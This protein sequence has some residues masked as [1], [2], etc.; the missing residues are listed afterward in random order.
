MIQIKVDPK[1]NLWSLYTTKYSDIAGHVFVGRP[2]QM[3]AAAT[4]PMAALHNTPA[5]VLPLLHGSFFYRALVF[6]SRANIVVCS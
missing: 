2:G 4:Q 3:A 6:L 1:E 5:P